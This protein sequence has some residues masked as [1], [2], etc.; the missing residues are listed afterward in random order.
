MNGRI[1]D[2][3]LGRFLQADPHI[4]APNNSQSYNRY[5]YV[6]NNP[7]SYTDPSGYFFKSL[8]KKLNKALGNFAPVFGLALMFVPGMQ[9][10]AAQ[11]IWHAAAVGFG[12]GGVSTGSLKG[13]LIG[14]FTGAAFHKIG[15][16]F[17]DLGGDNLRAAIGNSSNK[18]YNFGGNLLTSG[19]VTQ[20]IAAHAVVGG[21]AAELAGGK[22]GHGF[23]S[24]GVTKGAGGAFLPGGSNLSSGQIASGTAISAVIGG[25]VSKLT[26][27]KFANGAQT[28]AFQYLFNQAKKKW[29]FARATEEMKRVSR[30]MHSLAQ[31]ATN[32]Y[33]AAC[34]NWKCN[35][36]W[37]RGSG[38]H[39]IFGAKV[40]ALGPD[41]TPEQS[42]IDGGVAYYG[43]KGSVRADAI[44]GPI[45]SPIMA[46][47]LKTGLYDIFFEEFQGY[48]DNLPEGT[49]LQYIFTER[50]VE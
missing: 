30:M 14:A 42:Y 50:Q 41:F 22:F 35:V 31:D 13:A 28:G 19:Q 1:Y 20:Q 21:I 46:Y 39:R 25:T 11:S 27:G 48:R 43:Q 15:S 47:E 44:W 12:I 32:E 49:G 17:S 23:I 6:L 24:A 29:E 45:E 33:D 10:F 40:A 36:P 18:I 37:T 4:Q 5:S 38:I 9:A 16:H 34:A 3:T 8:F 26:G 2:P 7:L